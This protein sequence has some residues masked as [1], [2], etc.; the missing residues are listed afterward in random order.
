MDSVSIIEEQFLFLNRI[1]EICRKVSSLTVLSIVLQVI[2]FLVSKLVCMAN[3]T[4][5]I[6]LEGENFGNPTGCCEILQNNLTY[7]IGYNIES[8][9]FFSA[10]FGNQG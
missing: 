8:N 5:S 10:I 3:L 6:D 4:F 7:I 1:S 9:S 2:R